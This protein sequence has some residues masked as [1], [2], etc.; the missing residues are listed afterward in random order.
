[1][2]ADGN[3]NKPRW[4]GWEV[5]GLFSCCRGTAH[6]CVLVFLRPPEWFKCV[7][8]IIL[9]N[10]P[11]GTAVTMKEFRKCFKIC[12]AWSYV[13]LSDTFMCLYWIC[14]TSV[15][16]THNLLLQQMMLGMCVCVSMFGLSELTQKAVG[17]QSLRAYRK[18][19]MH[20]SIFCWLVLL[21]YPK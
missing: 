2:E 8:G 6:V 9:F 15:T 3:Q 7:P 19:A 4:S 16:L 1:M 21:A 10:Q 20:H 13:S 18:H 11:N 14:K 17:L 5:P 12:L